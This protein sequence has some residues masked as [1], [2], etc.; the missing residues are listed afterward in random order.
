MIAN[1]LILNA[2]YA[3]GLTPEFPVG[4]LQGHIIGGKPIVMWRAVDGEVVAFDDRCVHK[5]MPL[6]AGRLLDNGLLECA[7]HGLCYNTE[8]TCVKIPSQPDGPIPARAKLRPYSVV[9]QEGLVWLWPGDPVKIGNCRPPR[10]PEI[11]SD[12]WDTVSSEAIRVNANYRLVI[13]NLLDITHFYPLHAGNIGD[14]ANSLIP[15][16]F[17]EDI[18]DGNHTIKSIR[19]A[20]GYKQPPMMAD[21]FGHELVDRDHTHHMMNPGL[22]RV[23][24][25]VA[26]PGKLGAGEDRGYVL[27]HTHLPI[28]RENFEWHWIVNT[29]ARY[30]HAG[31]PSMSVAEHFSET[32]PSV[33]EE[34]RWALEKQQ[35]MFEYDDDGY[36]EVPLKTD[37]AVLSIRK[38]F[39]AL[40]AEESGATAA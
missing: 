16:T 20:E 9:E 26:P 24:I 30:K 19:H 25:R 4:E 6:S 33:L 1:S 23:E 12:D 5:R 15:V 7:Y 10:T 29:P 34:D 17:E 11:D 21:W 14:E 38:L 28:D 36:S 35:K 8:G 40:E 37:K 31:D 3:A 22:T 2:W 13:E 32:F 18:I 39:T 27:Y